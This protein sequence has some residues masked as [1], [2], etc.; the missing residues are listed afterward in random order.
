METSAGIVQM[1]KKVYGND[2]YVDEHEVVLSLKKMDADVQWPALV[3][4]WNS[5]ATGVSQLL[6]GTSI[7]V[8]GSS[9]DI[10]WAVARELAVGLEYVPLLFSIFRPH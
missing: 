2:R 7:Y 5:L 1:L 4:A 3:E 10:N 9:S 8:V 6:K